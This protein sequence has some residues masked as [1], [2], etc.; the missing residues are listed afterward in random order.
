MALAEFLEWQR[1]QELRYELVD[2][3]PQAMICARGRHDRVARRRSQVSLGIELSVLCPPSDMEEMVTSTPR[4]V[5]GSCGTATGGST[6]TCRQIS[7][8]PY[9][10]SIGDWGFKLVTSCWSNFDALDLIAGVLFSSVVL[11]NSR[12]TPSE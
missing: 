3:F 4:L 10:G 7:T 12:S 11:P 1:R 6:N 2:G 8:K 9:K 5:L